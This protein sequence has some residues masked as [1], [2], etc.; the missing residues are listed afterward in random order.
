MTIS[1][2]GNDVSEAIEIAM[3]VGGLVSLLIV[4]LLI[5][6]LVRPP[7]RRRVEAPSEIDAIEA[8]EML[9]LIDRMERRLEVLERA[10]PADHRRETRILET[11]EGPEHR[12]MK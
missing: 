8:E 12:R 10:L 6:L 11:G 9:A 3:A 5:Y 7:R 1:L 2:N 4:G